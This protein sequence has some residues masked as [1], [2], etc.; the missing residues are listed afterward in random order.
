MIDTDD[1]DPE[2]FAQEH[3]EELIN[4]I[5]HS[6]DA[7]ARAA[8]WTLLDRSTPDQ[9]VEELEEEFDTVVRGGV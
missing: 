6:D 9:D 7:F 3:R 4:V 1:T 2:T 8:A 5:R